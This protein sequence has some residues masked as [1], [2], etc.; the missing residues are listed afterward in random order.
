MRE[1]IRVSLNNLGGALKREIPDLREM[2]MS[3]ITKLREEEKSSNASNIETVKVKD[4]NDE[5]VAMEVKSPLVDQTNAVKIGGGSYPPLS[6]QGITPVGNT[7]N[8]WG[9]FGFVKSMLNSSTRLFSFQFS[10]TDGLNSMLK[11]GPW[12]IRNHPL[13]LRKWNPD[14]DLLKEDVGNVPVWVKLH[15][16]P[17]TAFSEDGLSAIATKL[18]TPLMLDSYTSDMCLQS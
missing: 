5:P 1:D 10:S 17:V 13:I 11:N 4:L 14:V 6:I 3:K 16:V 12:F 2:F 7:L 8:T 9:K 15:G 18:G